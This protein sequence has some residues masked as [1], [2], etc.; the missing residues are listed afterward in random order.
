[1][2]RFLGGE[3]RAFGEIVDRYQRR[4]LNFVYRTIGDR[5]SAEDVVQDAFIRVYRHL[6][7]FDRTRKFSTWIYTIAANLAKN[8]LRRRARRPLVLFGEMK[9]TWRG[10]ERPLELEDGSSRP[11]ALLRKR[12]LRALVERGMVELSAHHRQVFVLR[13]VEGKSYAQIA[14]MTS[15]SLGTVKSRLNRARRSFGH[16]L[17]RWVD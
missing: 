10:E 7:R 5:A 13:D 16:L 11:E 4:L 14:A 3:E 9:T 15:S 8:E 12:E 1:M 17:R 6:H 2:L